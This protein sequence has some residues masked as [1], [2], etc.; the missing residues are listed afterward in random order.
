MPL[1]PPSPIVVLMVEFEDMEVDALAM[2]EVVD[3]MFAS[4]SENCPL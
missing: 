4:T 1:L 2:A 3:V